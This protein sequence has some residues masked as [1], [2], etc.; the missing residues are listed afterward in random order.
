MKRFNR[1][2]RSAV[3]ALLALVVAASAYAFTNSN[4]VDPSKAGIGSGTVSGYNVT[5]VH[6][7]LAANNTDIAS[8][9]FT[10][11][12]TATTVKASLNGGTNYASCTGGPTAWSCAMPAGVT[13][14]GATA[15]DVVA[16]Q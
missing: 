11:D 10:L 4:T 6:Y 9:S 16:V 14:L 1:K 3:V 12:D 7:A 15:L 8:V 13:V 5:N 2:R